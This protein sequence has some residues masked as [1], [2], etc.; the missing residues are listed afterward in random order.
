MNLDSSTSILYI[1]HRKF[2]TSDS[3]SLG[4][5]PRTRPAPELV[6]AA[7]EILIT[8][9]GSKLISFPPAAVAAVPGSLPERI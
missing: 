1:V 8:H 9:C 2:Y 5:L 6:A 4:K 3:K 7:V